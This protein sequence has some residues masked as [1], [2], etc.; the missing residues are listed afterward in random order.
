MSSKKEKKVSGT[1]TKV[2]LLIL[3]ALTICT[4]NGARLMLGSQTLEKQI[5]YSIYSGKLAKQTQGATE[6]VTLKTEDLD[7]FYGIRRD[8]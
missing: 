3:L 7:F 2:F 5:D 6:C 8:S 4:C 1:S